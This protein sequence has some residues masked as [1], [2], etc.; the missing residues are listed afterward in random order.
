MHYLKGDEN[1]ILQLEEQL[2]KIPQFKETLK[3]MGASL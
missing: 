2:S 1:M 3:E